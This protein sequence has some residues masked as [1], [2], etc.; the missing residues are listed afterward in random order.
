MFD[1]RGVREYAQRWFRGFD[2]LGFKPI[3]EHKCASTCG[4]DLVVGR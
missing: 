4:Y 3:V 1:V 2:R